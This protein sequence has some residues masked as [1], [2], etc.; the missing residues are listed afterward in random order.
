MTNAIQSHLLNRIVKI[1]NL[2]PNNLKSHA[3]K[4]IQKN[5]KIF[6]VSEINQSITLILIAPLLL[7]K[8]SLV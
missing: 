8:I 6:K 5:Q 3:S 2:I 1:I 4:N 7:A